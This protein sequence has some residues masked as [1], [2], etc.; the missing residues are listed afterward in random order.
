MAS[1]VPLMV[2]KH[3]FSSSG[4]GGGSGIGHGRETK[5]LRR[6]Q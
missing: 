3:G 6:H 4:S 2:C 1:P 5:Q